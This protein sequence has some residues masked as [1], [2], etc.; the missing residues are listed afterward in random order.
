[1]CELLGMECNVPTDIVFSFSGLRAPR[2]QDGAARGRLG[3]RALRGQFARIFLEP[4]AGVR[5]PRSPSSSA[6]TRSRRCSRSRTSAARRAGARRSRTR[7]RSCASCGGA[8]RRSR[9]TARCRDVQ[10]AHARRASSRIGTTDSE[11]AF[12]CA[13]RTAARARSRRLS[14][15]RPREL[16]QAVA[17]HRR[18]A[19]RATARSTSCSATARHLFARCATKLHYIIRKAPFR[20]R[21]SRRRPAVDFAAVTTPRDRVAVVATAPL[22]RD[23]AWTRATPGTLWVFSRGALRATLPSGDRADEIPRRRRAPAAARPRRAA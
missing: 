10:A 23:E 21:R 15:R 6:S 20:R 2:R 3:A 13:A 7:T 12:C 5:Q 1:M 9:T 11:H 16:W 22:T 8:T 19:R 14:R 18:R 17:E 4:D